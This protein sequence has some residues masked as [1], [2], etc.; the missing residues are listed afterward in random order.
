MCRIYPMRVDRKI[1][2]RTEG[3]QMFMNLNHNGNT[4]QRVEPITPD[5]F[6]RYNPPFK[7]RAQRKLNSSHK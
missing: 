1:V 4:T 7:Q 2:A 3:I 6:Y 5:Y